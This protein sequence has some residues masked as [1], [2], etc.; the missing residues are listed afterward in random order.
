[1]CWTACLRNTDSLSANSGL[2]RLQVQNIC[3]HAIQVEILSGI[4]KDDVCHLKLNNPQ[5]VAGINQ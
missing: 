1:M 5:T 2:S 3:I 4:R